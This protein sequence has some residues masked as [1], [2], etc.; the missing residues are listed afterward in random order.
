MRLS[1]QTNE[2]LQN[3]FREYFDDEKL[4]LPKIRIYSKRGAG[5]ITKILSI[6]GITIGR[7]ILIKPN[8]A[9]YDAKNRLTISKNLLSHEVTHVVQYQQLG[10][11]GFLY[12][13]FKDYY[14]ILRSKKRWDSD[15]RLEA[16]W[17]IPHEIEARRAAQEFEKWSIKRR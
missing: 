9:K 3:F 14:L 13:Y 1:R 12:K 11:F 6:H 2:E 7:H 5:F 16:Y 17:E 15:S 4:T 8:Q 10:F